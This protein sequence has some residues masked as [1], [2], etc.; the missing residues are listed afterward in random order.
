MDKRQTYWLGD[1]RMSAHERKRLAIALVGYAGLCVWS[2][3]LLVFLYFLIR[4][5]SGHLQEIST[6]R[7]CGYFYNG[8]TAKCWWRELPVKR[9]DLLAV[10]L[11]F[12]QSVFTDAM[13]KFILFASLAAIFWALQVCC[14]PCDQRQNNLV[15]RPEFA[16]LGRCFAMPFSSR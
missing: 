9:M 1:T 2:F 13:L 11:G 10:F 6:M 16:G 7:K 5:S 4:R 14:Q 8:C 15:N 3:G 12:Y